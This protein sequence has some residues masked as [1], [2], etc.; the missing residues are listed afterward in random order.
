MSTPKSR[1]GCQ[2]T[3]D[4]YGPFTNEKLLGR[5]FKETGRRKEIFLASKFGNSITNG[6]HQVRGDKEYVKQAVRECHASC[7]RENLFRLHAC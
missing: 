7:E 6:Q 5:W 3:S 1:N 4:I 2:D